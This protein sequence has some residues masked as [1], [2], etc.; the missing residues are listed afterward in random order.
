MAKVKLTAG[1]IE[2]L[3]C[4][5]DKAQTFLWDATANGLGLRVTSTGAKAY[6]F[7][8]KLNGQ[9]L[10]LTIG[11]P[12]AWSID[13]ARIEARR[14]TM[15]IDNGHDPRE[16]KAD[17][18]AAKQALKESKEAAQREKQ[19]QLT[20]QSITLKDVWTVYLESRKHKWGEGHYQ[21]HLKLAAEGGIKRKRGE[22]VTVAAPL[23]VLMPVRLADLTSATIAAWLAKEAE[24]RPTNAAQSFRILRAMLSWAATMPAYQDIVCADACK[25][26]DVRDVMPKNNQ[27]DDLLQREQLPMWFDAVKRISNPVISAYLQAL[28]ITG[29]RR[30]ELSSLKWE[31]IDFQWNS[32]TIRDKVEGERTIPLT[33][34]V[35]HLLV[36]LPRRNGWVFSSPAAADGRLTE[37]RIA[38]TKALIAVGLPHVSLHG[39][40]RSFGTL[41][42]WTETPTGVVAQIM[43]HKPSATAEKHYRRRPLDMLRM[44]HTKLEAWILEQAQIDFVPV[45]AGLRAVK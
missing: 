40:R 30:R 12:Q 39:L 11:S 19:N 31:D 16:V 3:K 34:Y 27:K 44:W 26:R 41:C 35:S 22:G 7:Q 38:H 21:N 37:P 14:L 13:A 42:E 8:S 23:A 4:E 18:L 43:G 29:A 5:P 15:L 36:A 1:R 10:R 32:L 25:A 20:R 17:A 2:E 33:P 45:Q 6:I 28:L 24:T 9:T